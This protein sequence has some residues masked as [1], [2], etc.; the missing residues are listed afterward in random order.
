MAVRIRLSG[1][2]DCAILKAKLALGVSGV[3]SVAFSPDGQTLASS[4]ADYY[5]KDKTIKLWSVRTGEV[6]KTL[7]GDCGSVNCIAFS[8][9]GQL[10]VSGSGD[11]TIKLWG[12]W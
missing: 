12:G 1:Y 8:P 7:K 4:S 11:G 10:L 3:N 6:I 5:K 2:G 9:D